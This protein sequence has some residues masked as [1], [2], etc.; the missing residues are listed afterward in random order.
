MGHPSYGSFSSPQAFIE[1]VADLQP[2]TAAFDCDGTLW[3]GDSG[4]KFFYW[5]IEQGLI[6]TKVAQAA[7]AQYDEYLAGRVSEDDICREMV[8]IH[9]GLNLEKVVS[10]AERFAEDNVV[11]H[12]FPEMRTLVAKLQSLNCDIWA[13]SSTNSWVIEAAVQA[14]G[15]R[16]D[17]VLAVRAEIQNGVITDHIGAITSGPG[18]AL[19]L[20][21]AMSAP[22]DVSFGNSLFD[23]EMLALARQAFAINAEPDLLKI[24]EGKE[25]PVYRPQLAEIASANTQVK[26]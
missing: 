18:K 17:R 12:Y 23:L 26:E 7:I 22:P 8:R 2:R 5:E 21:S 16:S 19:A 25:W 6:P 10:F 1:S 4:M 13:V 20:R 9:A 11:P 3:F 15:I 14:V 24:A